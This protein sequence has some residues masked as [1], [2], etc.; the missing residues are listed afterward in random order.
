MDS[1]GH[2]VSGRPPSSPPAEQGEN[3]QGTEHLGPH[4]TAVA[5]RRAARKTLEEVAL[6]DRGARIDQEFRLARHFSASLELLGLNLRGSDWLGGE[7]D[8]GGKLAR[9][10]VLRR[11]VLT[12]I[13]WGQL[14]DRAGITE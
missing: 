1:L 3:A 9:R 7:L 13:F 14:Q 11:I 4:G 10:I 12:H 2:A 5:A 6:V 8:K